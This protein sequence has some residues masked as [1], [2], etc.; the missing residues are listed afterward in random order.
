MK[1]VFLILAPLQDGQ[2]RTL[3]NY[4]IELQSYSVKYF[5]THDP[6]LTYIKDLV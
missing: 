5:P 4:K 3:S 2:F 1:T 6:E